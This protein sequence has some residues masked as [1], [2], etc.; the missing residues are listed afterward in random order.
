MNSINL[1][2]NF[3]LEDLPT[4]MTIN[5][6]EFSIIMIPNSELI[7]PGENIDDTYLIANFFLE[8][9]PE[10]FVNPSFGIGI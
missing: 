8:I 10:S 3:L 2:R 1:Y 4:W 5:K 9:E 7:T 6:Q